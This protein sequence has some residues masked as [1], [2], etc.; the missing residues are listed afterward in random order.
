VINSNHDVPI[1]IE[2]TDRRYVVFRSDN[3]HINQSY[4]DTLMTTMNDEAVCY[5]FYKFLLN[6]DITKWKYQED[7]PKTQVYEELKTYNKCN[8]DEW[9]EYFTMT[10]ICE[11]YK[12][13]STE[14]F[15]RY[16]KYCEELNKIPIKHTKFGI[17]LK[18]LGIQKQRTTKGIE[19]FFV[20]KDLIEKLKLPPND[21]DDMDGDIAENE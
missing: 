13:G 17:Q 9:I 14:L 19:Y 10:M 11:E 21:D 18:N 7:R 4:F 1:K 5:S 2:E 3:K 12:I 15:K 16:K 6:R 8:F 20:K